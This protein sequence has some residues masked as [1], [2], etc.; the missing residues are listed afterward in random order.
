LKN[1]NESLQKVMVRSGDFILVLPATTVLGS[2]QIKLRL[3]K[4]ETGLPDSSGFLQELTVCHDLT[5]T[6]LKQL[7]MSLPELSAPAPE[8]LR[9]RERNKLGFQGRVLRESSKSLR[10][11]NYTVSADFLIQV[12]PMPEQ[13]PANALSLFACERLVPLMD[14]GP[15]REVLLDVGASPNI[16]QLYEAVLTALELPWPRSG[17]TIAKYV[18]HEFGWETIKDARS[19]A[20]RGN[21]ITTKVAK[22]KAAAVAG[23][24]NL[25]KAPVNLKEGDLL[26][27]RLDSTAGEDDFQSERDMQARDLYL[28]AKKATSKKSK[29]KL[30]P[31]KGV[32]IKI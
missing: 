11:L 23:I 30:A 29:R 14:F 3:W 5:V 16:D 22:G 9:I 18:P 24:Y 15:F 8:Y 4:S 26:A 28:A 7:L 1:D 10:K 21:L 20:E 6:E 13:L 19:P 12:L 25:K 31:E 2:E 32:S 17:V 27:V